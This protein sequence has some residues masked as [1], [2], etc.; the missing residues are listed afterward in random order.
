MPE[1]KLCYADCYDNA[2][3]LSTLAIEYKKTKHYIHEIDCKLRKK[4]KSK[5]LVRGKLIDR[6]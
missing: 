3:M 2:D 6:H 1:R 5:P 4:R